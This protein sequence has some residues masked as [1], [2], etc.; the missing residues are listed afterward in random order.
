MG[1]VAN[2]IPEVEAQSQ[3]ASILAVCVVLSALSIATV[4]CRLWV[5]GNS[6]GFAGDDYMSASSMVFAL[7]YSVLCV[8]QTRYGLGLPVKLRPQ[9]D[10]AP[11]ARV[12]F[13][14]RPI[15]QVGISFF[16]IALLISYLR[17]LQG[18]DHRTYRLVV[19]A[20]IAIVFLAHVGCAISLIFACSPVQK[21]WK[22]W[23]PGT[24]LQPGPSFTG[25]AVVTIISDIVVAILPVPV[26][27]RLNIRLEKKIG[28]VFLF[29]LGLFTTLCSIFR[30][31][32]IDRIQNGDGNSTMLVLWGT[33]EFNVGNMV[34]SLPF[35]APVCM[36]K[37]R[38]YRYKFSG[39]Y[40]SNSDQARGRLGLVNEHYKLSD[41]G[42]GKSV[43]ST[44]KSISQENMLE[45]GAIIKSVTYRVQI[46]DE[47]ELRQQRDT[48]STE[49][50]V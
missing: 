35:L 21:S 48:K 19:R 38:D 17:L 2:A 39:G 40:G 47:G 41:I 14:G 33:I 1:W 43:F 36:K 7:V 37:A 24:C 15:Y 45:S 16:K 4:S 10:A 49:C 12:N 50:P 5:R 42:N 18:T 46:L 8:V 3:W 22:P 31:I 26:L 27:L 44:H 25:Y 34:S 20:T 11:Y 6:R 9:A 23:V 32:Q 13:A 28:L 30:Y 29:M